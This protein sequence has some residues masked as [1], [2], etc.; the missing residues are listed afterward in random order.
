MDAENIHQ[1]FDWLWTSG[2]LSEKDI[3]RLKELGIEAVINLAPTTAS[4]ALS[5]EA[6]FV[7]RQGIDYIR[8]PVAW[9]QPELH[10][11]MQFFRTLEAYQERNVWVHCAKNMRVSVFIY[12]YRR[13][14]L[15]ESE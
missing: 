9:E 4:N 12:L 2:Q 10:R 7:S 1:V 5:G 14:C 3:A 11:L 13:L 8:I 6:E 15:L